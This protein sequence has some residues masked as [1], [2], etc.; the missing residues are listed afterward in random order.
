MT[1]EQ[2]IEIGGLAD[3]EY[4]DFGGEANHDVEGW[5]EK[6]KSIGIISEKDVI[7][8]YGG[9]WGLFWEACEWA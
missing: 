1:D 4:V 7:K 2:W 8:E 3:Q 5:S 6:V 9:W